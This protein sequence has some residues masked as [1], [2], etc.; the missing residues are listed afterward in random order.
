M[1]ARI[2]AVA[3]LVTALLV[4][5]TASVAQS[6]SGIPAIIP[7][8]EVKPGLRGVG[9]TVIRGQR[10]DQFAFEVVGVLQGGGGVIPVKHLILFRVSGPVAER[11][12][13]IAAGMSGSP[14]YING[15][16][17]GALSAGYLFL[18]KPDA[19]LGL[20]TPIE[21][22]L[23]L[24]DVESSSP[25]GLWP[26]L[27][28]AQSP[29]RIGERTVGRVVVTNDAA[30]AASVQRALPGTA[31]FVPAAFPATVTGLSPRAL[32]LVE[33]VLGQK[34]PLQQFGSGQTSFP[35]ASLTGGSSI[36]VMQ[37]R[38]DIN[39]GGICTATLR[40]GNKLLIC[41]HPWDQLGPVEY[42]M[43]ASDIITVVRTLERPFKEGNLGDHVGMIDQDR[44]AGIRG[45]IGQMPRMFAVRVNVTNQDDGTTASRGMLVV[46][47]PDLAKLFASVMA[48]T[49]VDRARG[50]ILG[51]GT[52]TVRVT[53][54]ARGLPRPV[55][56]ENIFYNSRDIALAAVLDVPAG[57][58]FLYYNDLAAIDPI[59]MSID[60]GITAKRVTAAIT[61]VAVERR[62]L[63][64]GGVL[65]VR[66]SVRPYQEETLLSRVID[67][68][69][70]R[71]Y[72]RGPAI[73]SIGPLVAAFG[74]EE[75]LVE[76]Q[77]IRALFSE[78]EPSPV[79][80][81]DDAIDIF[82]DFGKNTDILIRV[83]PFGLPTEGSD[84]VRFDVFAGR[85]IRTDWVIQGLIQIPILIR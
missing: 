8:S 18:D 15:R 56:R 26:R 11:S 58:N 45:I 3:V 6:P 82:E 81:L 48:L 39:F 1:I 72:P 44:G 2:V 16:L 41:G 53:L 63:T 70:P 30:S 35:P 84:F 73:L 65:R 74:G 19:D 24:L 66:L 43:T 46:R 25:A 57:L 68:T 28:T 10:I 52:A 80:N 36:G 47:R 51:G 5:L 83:I 55:T 37:V 21:E 20:A 60:I 54:R 7:L 61:D 12:G 59:D 27:F 62:E 79:D 9:R 76:N 32:R 14:M 42:A 33:R 23:P 13:G 75:Q 78:P 34:F 50:Q 85:A 38:G 17:M 64:P 4:P 40:V 77:F 69:I 49:A 31:A 29:V 71:N 22:M 67:V